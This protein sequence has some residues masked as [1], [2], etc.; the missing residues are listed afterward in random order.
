MHEADAEIQRLL[1][2]FGESVIFGFLSAEADCWAELHLPAHAC[3]IKEKNIGACGLA[4]IEVSA[5]VTVGV[6]VRK[7]MSKRVTGAVD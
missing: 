1:G 2:A 3:T 6:S 7:L 5:P 4:E